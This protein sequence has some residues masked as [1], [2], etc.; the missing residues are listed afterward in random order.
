F[1][2]AVQLSVAVSITQPVE[3][4]LVAGGGAVDVAGTVAAGATSV[5]VNGFAATLAG[6]TFSLVGLPLHE[7][8]NVLSAV[9]MD[10]AGNLGYDTVEV[11]V[12]GTQPRL[13]VDFPPQGSVHFDPAMT[14]SGMVHDP[15]L[16][17]TTGEQVSVTVNGRPASVEHRSFRAE[18]VPLLVGS[19]VLTVEAI[20]LAGNSRVEV[21]EVFYEPVPAAG[22][23]VKVS[24]DL[25]SAPI[26]SP[27]ALPLV[28]QLLDAEGNPRAGE[29]V[30][31][32]VFRGNGRFSGGER[33]LLATTDGAGQ[34]AVSWVLGS[35]AGSGVQ[36]VEATVAGVGFVSFAATAE[37]GAPERIHIVSGDGQQ[38]VPGQLLSRPLQVIVTDEGQNPVAGVEVTFEVTAGGGTLGGGASQLV[39]TD[40]RGYAAANLTVGSALGIGTHLAEASF[41]GQGQLPVLFQASVFLEGDPASTSLSGVVLDNAGVPVPGYT[42]SFLGSPLEVTS[43]PAGAFSLTGAPVG[44]QFLLADGTTASRPGSWPSLEFEVFLLGGIENRMSRPIFV[45]PLDVAGGVTAGGAEEAV[46]EI[47]EVPG[48]SL[49]VA[50]GSATFPDGLATG[51]VSATAVHADKIPMAPPEGMQPR[52][53]VTVQP[54]GATFDPPA[55][56]TFPNVDGLAPGSVTEMF[57]FDHD[58]G[59]FVSIGTGTVS[60]DGTVI[61]SDPG[62]G[63]TKAGWHCAA[64]QSGRGQSGGLRVEYLGPNPLVL[65]AGTTSL[66]QEEV[67][68]AA[69][70]PA[71]SGEYHWNVENS[72]I[73]EITAGT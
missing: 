15:G 55:P 58:L 57:S 44:H 20:D 43:G 8:T 60:S 27:L 19:N 17:T 40:A 54:A 63:I 21:L 28:V 13:S 39:T 11:L 7:G 53:I 72:G 25:Q 69:G 61:A 56:V 5:T 12:D 37:A 64:P 70:T 35:R 2:L 3:G 32:E 14:V 59:A 34:A 31:F 4:T 48:F 18:N 9:A 45:L 29:T 66:L 71:R 6:G 36:R 33:R 24:G 1:S 22:R 46:V 73:A 50:P 42:L 47:P 49:R 41:A 68:E 10:G 23:L 65:L 38:G 52:F 16:G 62:F 26:L 67:V 51:V 30:A